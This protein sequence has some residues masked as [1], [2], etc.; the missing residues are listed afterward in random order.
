M[1]ISS[2]TY[3]FIGAACRALCVAAVAFLT[4]H[5]AAATSGITTVGAAPLL[6]NHSGHSATLLNSGKVLVVGSTFPFNFHG[7]EIYELDANRWTRVAGTRI[8]R[9]GHGAAL[10]RNGRVL[11]VGGDSGSVATPTVETFNPATGTWT[12][13]AAMVTPRLEPRLIILADGRIFVA[14]GG[15][16]AYRA[17]SAAE[18]YDPSA[19]RWTSTRAM[20]ISRMQHIM[21]RL[22]DGRV[23]VAGGR[24]DASAE[25]YDPATDIWS[26][27]AAMNARR[28]LASSTVLADGRVLVIG[29]WDGPTALATAE[30]YDPQS[31]RWS[32]TGAMHRARVGHTATLMP[33]GRVFVASGNAG[34]ATAT[35][36]ETF[37]P[38]TGA[39]TD[40][41]DLLVNR[42][43]HSATL[44][45]DGRVLLAGGAYGASE[46]VEVGR[47]PWI[48]TPISGPLLTWHALT[49]LPD[50]RVLVTGGYA[51][52]GNISMK[53]WL[54][55]P[56]SGSWTN[57][58]P[59]PI[60]YYGH[61]ATLLSDGR[62]LVAG[63]TIQGGPGGATYIY[64]PAANAWS[65]S[66]NLKS[67]R[68][69]HCGV[70][71]ADGRVL[72]AGGSYGGRE[73]EIYDPATNAWSSGGEMLFSRIRGTCTTL[74][75]GR[76]MAAGGYVPNDSGGVDDLASVEVYRPESNIW[77]SVAPLNFPRFDA[78]SVRL[79]NGA[80]AIVGGVNQ[81]GYLGRCEMYDPQVDGWTQVC[82]LGSN[83]WTHRTIVA[84]SGAVI[85]VGGPPDYGT[86]ARLDTAGGLLTVG[87]MHDARVMHEAV[88]LNDG[89]I[90]VVGG[91]TQDYARSVAVE[92]L[93]PPASPESRRPQV[94]ALPGLLVQ[95]D[96]VTAAGA[97]FTGRPES[98][99]EPSSSK[100]PIFRV[101]RIDNGAV[102]PLM[103]GATP[104]DRDHFTSA[105]VTDLAQGW[106][107]LSVTVDGVQSESRTFAVRNTTSVPAS[108]IQF[109]RSGYAVNEF[110]GSVTT[111]VMRTGDCTHAAAVR[112]TTVDGTAQVGKHFMPPATPVI[113]WDAGDCFPKRVSIAVNDNAVN[114][115]DRR[116]EMRLTSPGNA[117][118]GTRA[119]TF[120]DI[121]DDE[122]AVI[123]MPKS[124]TVV[125]NP[126]GP[127][128]V[129]GA[130]LSGTK[131][132]APG[133]RVVVQLGPQPGNSDALQL[134][135]DGFTIG[136]GNQLVI[137]AGAPGQEVLLRNVDPVRRTAIEGAV[138]A[139]GNGGIAPP[140]I[141]LNDPT[142]IAILDAGRVTGTGGVLLDAL[143]EN[144]QSGSE[145]VNDG[146]IDGDD[147]GLQL[148]A[149]GI[150]GAGF[151]RGGLIL[152]STFG[153]ANNPEY[154]AR[155]LANGL[156][157][158]PA[159]QYE[160]FLTL[161]GYGGTPQFFNVQVHGN[162]LVEMPSTSVRYPALPPNNLPLNGG[163]DPAYGGGSLIVQASGG[164][165]LWSTSFDNFVFPGGVV[166][167]AGARIDTAGVQINNGWTGSGRP[168][169]G[170]FLEAPSIVNSGPWGP[171]TV[172]VTN[173][174]N[175]VNF[176]SVPFAPVQVFQVAGTGNGYFS[177]P[178]DASAP[179]LNTYSVLIEAAAA[180]KCWQCLMNMVPAN[181]Q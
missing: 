57:G 108:T 50:G 106:Y 104:Y 93:W 20:A 109:A 155:Y 117:T 75:D 141:H 105:V 86:V 64:D 130:V 48:G 132:T 49:A 22:P 71:L 33:D 166:F 131:I 103:P 61:T 87:Q 32:P 123:R 81:M 65:Y 41:G 21:A 112:V 113:T 14:G 15:I 95:P 55:E 140:R 157:L 163:L 18:I 107:R 7:A 63:G 36:A 97:G 114:D 68:I 29:G 173:N 121:L 145:I 160:L 180:G 164:L 91:V 85:N 179:H 8:A 124:F 23:L 27:A 58:A 35:T 53:T 34:S 176:S 44:L 74:A 79:S 101:Q 172:V 111:M 175:W 56:V 174:L 125:A 16:D 161:N 126:Y 12:D 151:F 129:E 47:K 88:A 62:V 149:S 70:L 42:S 83:F 120:V 127:L 31:N 152:L 171:I 178:A 144:W 115:G 159:N 110:A 43:D 170:V 51:P 17:T 168:F 72:L 94:T 54:Y 13:A 84:A 46:L 96:T 80:V 25:I 69:Q 60:E 67:P 9:S 158:I 143:G 133:K 39:W 167:K 2:L 154:G 100:A 45:S 156:N 165:R 162:A 38:A 4:A 118:L 66:G 102:V 82:G 77:R 148:L 19:N 3:Q 138:V 98:S 24:D 147:A 135:L 99:G 142:G 146:M 92:R 26:L 28:R 90:L 1:A 59:M 76:V 78:Q 153:S 177:F 150:H 119:S 30:I 89:S 169:Q 116:F 10:L 134:D 181:F 128:A 5:P 40:E 11:V 37:D 6:Q 136:P 137:R 52:D 139:E 122:L 73:A